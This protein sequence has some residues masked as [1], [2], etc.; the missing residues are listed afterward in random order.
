MEATTELSM[1]NAVEALLAQ[2]PE[3]AEV[4]TTDTE[5]EEVD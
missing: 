1:D 4:E 3:T 2:E 5:T